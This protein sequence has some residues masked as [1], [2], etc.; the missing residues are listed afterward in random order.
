MDPDG[1]FTTDAIIRY[2]YD[3]L[4]QHPE[5]DGP[6]PCQS[7][8]RLLHHPTVS[9]YIALYRE[10]GKLWA[11][12][13]I[14][15]MNARASAA[16]RIDFRGFMNRREHNPL[17]MTGSRINLANCFVN[18]PDDPQHRWGFDVIVDEAGF[19]ACAELFDY[20]LTARY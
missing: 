3:Q 4:A 20:L 15:Y 11:Q 5:D 8:I 16:N 2:L 12:I 7:N 14:G 1:A 9:A 19:E 13:R 17:R 18:A 10:D 6:V